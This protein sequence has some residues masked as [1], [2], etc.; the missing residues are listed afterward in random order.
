MVSAGGVVHGTPPHVCRSSP[1]PLPHSQTA[2]IRS[3][4]RHAS[5]PAPHALAGP[6]L[7]PFGR[8]ALCDVVR[9]SV[10]LCVR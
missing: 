8:H 7:G 6:V 3:D 10:C 5:C 9:F 4:G 1:A 2:A